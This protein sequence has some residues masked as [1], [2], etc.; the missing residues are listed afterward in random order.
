[1]S[2]DFSYTGGVS[3]YSTPLVTA[4]IASRP[5]FS[6]GSY[7]STLYRGKAIRSSIP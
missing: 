3:T 5:F 7:G 6:D 1:M 4:G 2:R